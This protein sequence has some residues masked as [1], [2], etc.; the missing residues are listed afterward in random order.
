[1]VLYYILLYL[2]LLLYTTHITIIIYY[3]TYTIIYLI[4]YYTFPFLS[5]SSSSSLL[6]F[7]HLSIFL[8]FSS[9]PL[10]SP[11]LFFHSTISFI[12]YL[13]GV[14]YTYLYSIK[15]FIFHQYINLHFPLQVLTPHV[16]SEWMVEV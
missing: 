1:M 13:S 5:I 8:L 7:S 9:S 4:L 6:S 2:I 16:L 15:I 11:P 14:T 12:L 10:F 3:Y